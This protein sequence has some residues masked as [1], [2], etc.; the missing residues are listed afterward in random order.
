MSLQGESLRALDRAGGTLA[1]T[2]LPS[3]ASICLEMITVLGGCVS[4]S[5]LRGLLLLSRKVW[6]FR[7]RCLPPVCLVWLCTWMVPKGRELRE[8]GECVQGGEE[9]DREH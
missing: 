8:R 7:P 3:V 4:K 2:G 6:V 9:R 1:V 5:E